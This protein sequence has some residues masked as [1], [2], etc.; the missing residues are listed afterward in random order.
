MR[1]GTLN[2]PFS[3]SFY[4]SLTLQLLVL[5]PSHYHY[6]SQWHN[7]HNAHYEVYA[8]QEEQEEEEEEDTRILQN[9]NNNNN[10]LFCTHDDVPSS[11]STT[12]SSTKVINQVLSYLDDHK[13]SIQ[14]TILQSYT[15]HHE[16]VTRPSTQ[17]LYDDF[18]AS[19]EWM[20]RVGV[21]R[22]NDTVMGGGGKWNFYMGPDNCDNDGWHIGLANVAA[23]LGQSMT[24]VILNDT[25]DE[26]NWEMIFPNPNSKDP[27][28]FYPLSNACGQ[29]GV[30]YTK[31]SPNSCPASEEM[32]QCDVDPYMKITAASKTTFEG[33]APPPLECSPRTADQTVT[34]HYDPAPNNPDIGG[35][36]V[37]EEGNVIPSQLGRTDVE[38]CCW[39]GRGALH[40][41]GVCNLGKL[42]YYLGAGAAK[43]GRDGGARYPDIDFCTNPEAICADATRTMEMRWTVA[44][45]E[46]TER[47]QSHDD[48][49]MGW[50]Y[51]EEVTKFAMEGD[52]I[53][54]VQF[55][56]LQGEPSHF[57]DEVGGVLEQGCPFPPCDTE[58][59][60]RLR[61]KS[62]RKRN[63]ITAVEGV[64]LPVKSE[65]FRE[66]EEHFNDPLIRANF[67]DVL[68][69]SKSPVDGK[70]YQSYRYHFTDFME[71]LRKMADVGFGDNFFYIGQG[72]EGTLG[73]NSGLLNI[74][75]F[76]SYAIEMSIL[77]D[78]C[79][80]HNTQLVNGRF[81]V[82]NACG[83]YGAS[84]QDI[85]CGAGAEDAGKECP[86]DIN[87][88]FSAVTRTLDHRAPQPFKCAPKS[89][90]PV[91]GFWDEA[92]LEENHKTAF[93]NQIGRIDVE[94]CCWWGRGVLRKVT[95]GRCF[96]GQLNYYIGKRAAM[97]GRPSIYPKIDFCS[98]PEAICASEHSN[99]L[100][101]VSGMFYWIKQVQSFDNKDGWNYIEKIKELSTAIISGG[102]LDRSLLMSVDCILKTG[103]VDCDSAEDLT[104]RLN[105]VLTLITGFTLPTQSPTTTMSPS[106][107]PT[108]FPTVIPTDVPTSLPTSTIP[109][110]ASPNIF[111]WPSRQDVDLIIKIIE[112]KRAPIESDLLTPRVEIDDENLYSLDGFLSALKV[113]ADGTVQGLYFY[114]G[115][116]TFTNYNHR[117][118]GLVNVAAFLAHS[119]TEAIHNS[120][121]DERNV[122]GIEGKF[123]LSNSC[124]QHGVIYQN[125]RCTPDEAFM[126]C[127]PDPGLQ[128]SAVA[129][130]TS[131]DGAVADPNGPPAFFCGPRMYFPF[132]GYYDGESKTIR[133]DEPFSNRAGRTDVQ[134][135]CWWGRGAAQVK[136]VCMYGKLNY[137]IGA[138]A[139][140]EGR[141][142]LFPSVDVSSS[143]FGLIL[144]HGFSDRKL[145]P[146]PNL[147]FQFCQNPQAIC[148][149]QYSY[150]LMWVTGMF[151]WVEVVQSHPEYSVN[152]DKIADG[153][154]GYEEFI[155]AISD[156]LGS[157]DDDKIERRSNFKLA[158]D[159]IGLA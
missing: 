60:Q 140:E 50:N 32:Y 153:D 9:N 100:R 66:T 26:L 124:G 55:S 12:S 46:W 91:T 148:S 84:Y 135:C 145:T 59:P 4:I 147:H 45:F 33:D 90:Y 70:V 149:G 86:L 43:E 155:D 102:E 30:S 58:R 146:L 80:E 92:H 82:S 107:S 121:C 94:G 112:E 41:R 88:S 77:D 108:D 99:E 54:S 106:A 115:H 89:Q 76:L 136:G 6:P 19:L 16:N 11:T 97:E 51:I 134:S 132:T 65:L 103:S 139:K 152:L 21:D 25:C 114:V 122:D 98:F 63:F 120:I 150:S 53:S 40:T 156:I 104:D 96:F 17:Y 131:S 85:V 7:I 24:M 78:A 34:G 144:L 28:G 101:W 64:G 62:R 109:P 23:F 15:D 123:P 111:W 52:L 138:R 75:M 35:R 83:M 125:L 8:A 127:P 42:N 119:K 117:K 68:L 69:L 1:P 57:I 36:I 128:M 141:R 158:V 61:W 31:S 116:G 56:L 159:A 3:P 129:A 113:L 142:S 67:E 47:I 157:S 118:R 14:N 27:D 81:P 151:S 137:Y 44:L 93:T 38:G 39:W 126:E 130:L 133:N 154:M 10:N 2:H 48:G 49:I 18:R 74:A 37:N 73:E 13:R 5:L 72:M 79:D 71:S 105:E 20:A 87:Q 95:Q 143:F 22:P 110:S 29:S